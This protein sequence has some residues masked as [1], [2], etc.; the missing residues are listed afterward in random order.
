MEAFYDASTTA[1]ILLRQVLQDLKITETIEDCVKTGLDKKIF[2]E[3]KR[4]I[5]RKFEDTNFQELLKFFVA[6]YF[7]DESMDV[8]ELQDEG[9]EHFE[10]YS[11]LEKTTN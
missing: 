8:E 10:R 2:K 3:C 9:P 7:V 6:S 11:D 4:R 5:E 1:N